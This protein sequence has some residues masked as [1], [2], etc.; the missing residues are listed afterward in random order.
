[1]PPR[2]K[3]L[4][5]MTVSPSRKAPE[6]VVGDI[7][8]WSSQA[9]GTMKTKRGVVVEV[10]KAGRFPASPAAYY[11]TRKHQWYVVEVDGERYYPIANKLKKQIKH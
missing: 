7:V 4:N 3:K 11:G 2:S 5:A 8:T 9:A 6:L 10:V 1:M